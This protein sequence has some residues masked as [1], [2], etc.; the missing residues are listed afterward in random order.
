MRT[1][2]VRDL[3]QQARALLRVVQGGE[4]IVVTDRGRPVARLS[5]F[6]GNGVADLVAAGRVRMPLRPMSGAPDPVASPPGAPS[7]TAILESQRADERRAG[8][9]GFMTMV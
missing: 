8:V 4:S 3:R 2:G 5:P 9:C 1:V 6:T 7:I